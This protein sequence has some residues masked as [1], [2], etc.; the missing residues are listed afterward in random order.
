MSHLRNLCEMLIGRIWCLL[1][2]TIKKL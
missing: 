1:D 2:I